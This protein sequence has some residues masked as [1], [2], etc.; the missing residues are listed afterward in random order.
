VIAEIEASL[1][2]LMWRLTWFLLTLILRI[3][4]LPIL[5]IAVFVYVVLPALG[6]LV[7][8]LAV[9]MQPATAVAVL[10]VVLWMWRR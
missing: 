7:H 3:F 6:A 2:R 1:W 10:L 4:W 5:I 9:V 8:L